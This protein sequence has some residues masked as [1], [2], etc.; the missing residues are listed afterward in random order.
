MS[1]IRVR[2]KVKVRD[3]RFDEFRAVGA[4]LVSAVQASDPD[5][6][7]YAVYLNESTS[8]GIF[9]EHYGSSEG[10]LGHFENVGGL[11]SKIFDLCD[12]EPMEVHG[13][14][15]PAALEALNGFGLEI[16]FYSTVSETTR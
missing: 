9:L 7:A 3:G 6:V 2:A 12:V 11:F 15:S 14:P 8:T 4:E 16:T 5:T 13:E 10:M 1:E